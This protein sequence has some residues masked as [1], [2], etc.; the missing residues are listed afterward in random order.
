MGSKEDAC[1]RFCSQVGTSVG[2]C[3]LL[4]AYDELPPRGEGWAAEAEETGDLL[5]LQAR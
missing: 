3:F 5:L 1:G 2:V 4:S